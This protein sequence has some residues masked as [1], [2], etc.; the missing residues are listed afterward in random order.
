MKLPFANLEPL[1]TNYQPWTFRYLSPTLDL[2]VPFASLGLLL[3]LYQSWT[4]QYPLPDGIDLD[5]EHRLGLMV[6]GGSAK[7]FSPQNCEKL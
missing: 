6:N 5:S 2:Q 1:G 7:M 4:F 3:N